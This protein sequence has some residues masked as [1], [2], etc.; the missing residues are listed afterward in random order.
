M[1]KASPDDGIGIEMMELRP[2]EI[3]KPSEEN[4]RRQRKST[5]YVSG[6]ENALT[7]LRLRLALGPRKPR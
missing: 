7:L 2:K 1:K 3:Q 5:I 4:T 6:Q